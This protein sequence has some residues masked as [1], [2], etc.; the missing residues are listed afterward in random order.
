MNL[1]RFIFMRLTNKKNHNNYL[2][3]RVLNPGPPNTMQIAYQC[4]TVLRSFR[5]FSYLLFW[6]VGVPK[7]YSGLCRVYQNEK[8]CNGSQD[9]GWET[10]IS[11]VI[12]FVKI[13]L[14]LKTSFMFLSSLLVKTKSFSP[15]LISN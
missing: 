11:R 14:M 5:N 8:G 4:A 12:I 2:P 13:R 3:C 9:K 6:L 10:M 15:Y 1:Y 7:N